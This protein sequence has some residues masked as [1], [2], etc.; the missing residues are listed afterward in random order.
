MVAEIAFPLSGCFGMKHLLKSNSKLI[1]CDIE[2]FDFEMKG[3][4]F[5]LYLNLSIE[6]SA[7]KYEYF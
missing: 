4:N 2:E 1:T 6:Y 5:L 7:K 3:M